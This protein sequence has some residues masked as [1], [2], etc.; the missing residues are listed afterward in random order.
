MSH[1]KLTPAKGRLLGGTQAER[2]R[3]ELQAKV[4]RG[5][6]VHSPV[7][8]LSPEER[9]RYTAELLQREA[10]RS[11]PSRSSP[12]PTTAHI[13]RPPARYRSPPPPPSAEERAEAFVAERRRAT[14]PPPAPRRILKAAPKAPAVVAPPPAAALASRVAP[15]PITHSAPPRAPAFPPAAPAAPPAPRPAAASRK[16]PAQPP[17]QKQP[18]PKPRRGPSARVTAAMPVVAA[19][20]RDVGRAL[21]PLE[22]ALVRDI[23]LPVVEAA[24]EELVKQGRAKN[25]KPGTYLA[26]RR[27]KR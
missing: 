14:P 20:L 13:L 12:K 7:R 2:Y 4:Q 26:V 17:P 3:A 24:L 8:T 15:K 6:T 9:A 10:A 27:T 25:G 5:E 21:R 22:I 1:S 11:T 19:E 23:R 18:Q 16:A